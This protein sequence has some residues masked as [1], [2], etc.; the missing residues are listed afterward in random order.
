MKS[1]LYR[2]TCPAEHGAPRRASRNSA[3]SSSDL[4]P[5]DMLIRSL[6]SLKSPYCGCRRRALAANAFAHEWLADDIGDRCD[7]ALEDFE[8]QPVGLKPPASPSGVE[9]VQI[10]E[11][12]V[13]FWEGTIFA[14]HNRNNG[15]ID[16]RG[17]VLALVTSPVTPSRGIKSSIDVSGHAAQHRLWCCLPLMA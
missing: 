15:K 8:G 10:I 9:I 17:A 11:R 16:A 1:G 14:P 3:M 2:S 7:I 13:V 12:C 5:S 4:E 6:I